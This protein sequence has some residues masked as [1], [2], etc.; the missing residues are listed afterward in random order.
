M[1]RP[2]VQCLLL[3]CAVSLSSTAVVL[4]DGKP[5]QW[6]HAFSQVTE[7]PEQNG[8]TTP[9]PSHFLHR[10]SFYKL[11]IAATDPYMGTMGT[12]AEDSPVWGLAI[13][14]AWLL[15]SGRLAD[16]TGQTNCGL[17]EP[18]CISLNSW[19][20]CMSYFVSALPF[21]SAAQQ[22]FLIP[23]MQVQMQIPEG[24]GEYCSNYADCA[25]K[26]PDAMNKWDAFFQGLRDAAT[27][28][29]PDSEKKDLLLGLYWAAQM[30]SI[31]A[32]SACNA[33]QSLYSSEE[34][35]FANSWLNSAEYVSA[36]HF[37]SNLVLS[38]KFVVPLPGRVL[39]EGDVAPN[40]ADLTA[41]ENHS[42]NTFT[43]MKNINTLLGGTLVSMWQKAMCS[44]TT[45][46]KGRTLLE[47]LMLDPSFATPTFLSI[48][49][50]MSTSC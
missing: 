26:Y 21:L 28:P 43:W 46:E 19:W 50:G 3:A 7:L 6:S 13:Q 23:G 44:P 4:E 27:S 14:L 37:Q 11:L 30:A 25:T 35:S 39:K 15:S 29:L 40:I 5:L 9:N 17:G 16:P 1:L 31:Y 48:I 49:T 18:M 33:K 20:S 38:S 2:V 32:S 22:G 47:Q 42:L 41:E 8:V 24:F 45:R 10:M 12:G 34:I 36:A